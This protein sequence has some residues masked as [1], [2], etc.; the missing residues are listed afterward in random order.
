MNKLYN[1]YDPYNSCS[2]DNENDPKKSYSTNNNNNTKTTNTTNNKLYNNIYKNLQNDINNNKSLTTENIDFIESLSNDKKMEIILLYNK[3]V[4][5][6]KKLL[7]E[8]LH[9]NLLR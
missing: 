1:P 9:K 4:E 3:V 6:N 2:T 7:D 5:S 8:L